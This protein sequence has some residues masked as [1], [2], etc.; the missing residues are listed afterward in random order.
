MI[1]VVVIIYLII[2]FWVATM[3]ALIPGDNQWSVFDGFDFLCCWLLWPL[4]L[5]YFLIICPFAILKSF[6][7]LLDYWV[8][9]LRREN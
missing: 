3:F 8:K 9:V 7:S 1:S 5:G 2:G 4:P 6:M